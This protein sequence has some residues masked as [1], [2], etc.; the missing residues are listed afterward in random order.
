[1]NKI[2]ELTDAQ[3]HRMAELATWYEA[4][5]LSGDDSYDVKEIERGIDLIYSMSEAKLPEQIIICTSPMDMA[6]QAK[7]KKGETFDYFGIGYDSGWTAWADFM[8]EIGVKYDPEFKFTEWKNFIKKSGVFAMTLYENVA[9]VCLRPCEVHTND[10]GDL[11]NTKGLAIAWRDGYC[12]Y[13]LN[14]VW[15]DEAIVMTPAEKIDP[16]L[17]L[18]EI[19]AEVRREIV[20]KIG[21]ERIIHKLG[22]EVLDK[23]G[24]YELLLLDLKD[25]RKRE[26]LK[27]LNPSIK[28]WH[29]EGVPPGTKTVAQALAW[30]NS[31]DTA[32]TVLT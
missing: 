12:E 6:K 9:F 10:V 18:K 20:R 8:E 28:V 16:L 11:H 32:P 21:M 22:A 23:Q 15:V 29:I 13:A 7:L 30:R 14:G 26:Y 25:G 17:M 27:M 24:D 1:M 5:A 31:T 2:E 4:N 3:I 19:N